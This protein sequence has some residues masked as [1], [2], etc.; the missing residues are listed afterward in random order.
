LEQ[1]EKGD[2][3]Q[4]ADEEIGIEEREGQSH[5]KH[6]DKNIDH[7]SLSKDPAG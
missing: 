5:E 2:T 4:L 3:D 6:D 7:A 1:T